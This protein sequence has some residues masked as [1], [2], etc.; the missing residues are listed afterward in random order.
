MAALAACSL[1]GG[2]FALD[3]DLEEPP[4]AGGQGGTGNVGGGSS[5]S[6]GSGGSGGS[7][8]TSSTT[9][10]EGGNGIGGGGGS[11]PLTGQVAMAQFGDCMTLEDW[12][13]SGMPL[14]ANQAINYQNN[15]VPCYGCHNNFDEGLNAMPDPN[16]AN[17][18]ERIEEAFEQM[19]YMYASFALVR[20]TV[21]PED[22]SFKG[23]APSYRWRDKGLD[24]NHGTYVLAPVY[25]GYY[26]D[27]YDRTYQKWLAGPCVP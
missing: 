4:E 2:C 24:V 3:W 18:S 22:G 5:G 6:G 9:G 26:E 19:R 15:S 8:T 25:V 7:S 23:L 10:G 21:N 17:A 13:D 20:W 1:V 27:W 11:E 16:A 14:I 12:I